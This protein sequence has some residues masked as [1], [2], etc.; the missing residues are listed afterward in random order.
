MRGQSPAHSGRGDLLNDP[1]RHK[2]PGQFE[3]ILAGGAAARQIGALAGRRTTWIATS[4]GKTALGTAAMGVR[5]TIQ[6]PGQK[7][8]GPLADDG[9]LHGDRACHLRVRVPVGQEQDNASPVY[10]AGCHRGRPLPVFQGRAL[11]GGQDKTYGG[12]AAACHGDL[13]PS[14]SWEHGKG[15]R[16]A[17]SHSGKF[18]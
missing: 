15:Y 9:A 1:R 5:E 13:L 4:G 16:H 6:A 7:P 12:L 10:Q 3:A 2:L 14:M 8:P 11:I 17:G 18:G